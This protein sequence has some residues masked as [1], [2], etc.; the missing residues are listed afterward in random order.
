MVLTVIV[1]FFPW[2]GLRQCEHVA[3]DGRKVREE[4]DVGAET[5]GA[6]GED[7]DVAVCKP[8]VALS[9]NLSSVWNLCVEIAWSHGE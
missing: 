2:G 7:N 9:F 6:F 4:G 3:K 8:E 5:A 1:E